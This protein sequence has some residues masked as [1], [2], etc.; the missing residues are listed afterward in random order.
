MDGYLRNSGMR[1][2]AIQMRECATATLGSRAQSVASVRNVHGFSC[3][4]NNT[5]WSTSS[6]TG[7]KLRR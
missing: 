3:D 7:A 2:S 5:P 6:F 1:R 4:Q